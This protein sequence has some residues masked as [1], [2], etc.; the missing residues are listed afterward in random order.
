M[1]NCL[2]FPKLA[3]IGRLDTAATKLTSPGVN[4][5]LRTMRTTNAN[6][7][8][9]RETAQKYVSIT[10]EA[11]VET[12]REKDARNTP[13]GNSPGSNLR[14]V[15]DR[16]DMILA[17]LIDEATGESLL[18]TGDRLEQI[19]ELD[20]TSIW[21]PRHGHTG[22]LKVTQAELTDFGFRMGSSTVVLHIEERPTGP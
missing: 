18:K 9:P 3:T 13:L 7:G 17:G 4:T 10:L 21:K 8:S 16:Q 6:D 12:G 2:I 5:A 15:C 11:Q 22:F 14:L 20:G 19:T 1:A